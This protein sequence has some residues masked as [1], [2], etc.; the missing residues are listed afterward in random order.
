MANKRIDQLPAA[1]AAHDADLLVADQDKGGGVLETRKVTL[2][3]VQALMQ[4]ALD[5]RYSRLAGGDDAD[6]VAMPKVDGSP[7]VESGS[8]ANGSWTKW[9]DGTMI[10]EVETDAATSSTGIQNS[11]YRGEFDATT[12]PQEFDTAPRVYGSLGYVGGTASAW[13]GYMP[14]AST[15]GT[16][17]G[18]F[19]SPVSTDSAK[20]RILAIGKWK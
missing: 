15:M 8:N 17:G 4:Q 2:A 9:A 20:L 10:C 18:R 19:L 3:Q 1:P 7:I 6:F 11:L 14:T 13:V 12:F 5:S 16:T